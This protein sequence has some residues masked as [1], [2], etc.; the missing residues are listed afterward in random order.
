MNNISFI[1]QFYPVIDDE[2]NEKQVKDSIINIL[3]KD[4]YRNTILIVFVG[5]AVK[6][7]KSFEVLK[8]LCKVRR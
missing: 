4:I 2:K 5:M 6:E 7:R 8:C 1:L 3:T